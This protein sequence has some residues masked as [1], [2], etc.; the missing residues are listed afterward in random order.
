M[1]RFILFKWD[2]SGSDTIFAIANTKKAAQKIKE[3]KEFMNFCGDG[4]LGCLELNVP[5]LS[6]GRKKQVRFCI[7]EIPHN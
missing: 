1:K 3:S 7:N 6:K 5:A 2:T 4:H